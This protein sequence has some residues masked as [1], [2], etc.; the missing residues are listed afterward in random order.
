LFHNLPLDG[1]IGNFKQNFENLIL[2]HKANN[3]ASQTWLFE[4]I[5]KSRPS[6][7]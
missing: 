1:D 7:R 3:I 6:D 4:E 5:E 2:L